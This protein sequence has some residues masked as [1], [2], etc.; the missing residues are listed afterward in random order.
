MFKRLLLPGLIVLLALAVVVV[1]T[2]GA[3]GIRADQRHAAAVAKEKRAVALFRAEVRPLVVAVFDTVQPLQDAD[4]AFATPRPGLATARDDVLAHSG[5]ST[6]LHALAVKLKARTAPRTLTAPALHLRTQLDALIK[7]ANA[8]AAAT[9][10]KA[11]TSG[12]VQAFGDG[13]EQLLTAEALW[14]VAVQEVYGASTTLPVPTASRTG[15]NGRH[16]PTKGG[17]LHTSDLICARAGTALADLPDLPLDADIRV[18]FPKAAKLVRTGLQTLMK[19]PAPASAAAFQHRLRTQLSA[20]L[21]APAAMDQM[22][23]A[24]K[25]LDLAAYQAAERRYAAALTAMQAVSRAYKAYGVSGCA[26]FFSVDDVLKGGSSGGL[27][28]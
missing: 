13:F 18:N 3:S 28:A 7:A 22:S 26:R 10:A 17:F 16:L 4:D 11:D 12:F 15:A 21:A 5:A 23:A 2:V 1:G 27:S 9:R 20:T 14:D 25:R 19:V 24:F 6:G 8:L